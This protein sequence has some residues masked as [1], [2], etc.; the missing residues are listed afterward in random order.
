[1]N[2]FLHLIG[3]CPDHSSILLF[4]HQ[5]YSGINCYCNH[6]KSKLKLY[7]TNKVGKK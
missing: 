5:N 2:E 3:L 6:A 1:M 4:I 7:I